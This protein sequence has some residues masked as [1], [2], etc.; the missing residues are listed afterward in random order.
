MRRLPI[1]LLALAATATVG[2][3]PKTAVNAK[4]DADAKSGLDGKRSGARAIQPNTPVTDEV[5]YLHQDQS[6]WY[7][8]QLPGH[9]GVLNTLVHWDNGASDIQIDV[10]DA[11]G[12][13][14][15]ASPVRNP[16][17]KEKAL[18][19]Q[20]DRPGT[21]YV[22]VTAPTA[23][24]GSV[25]TMEAKWD[26]PPPAPPPPPTPQ[27]MAMTEPAPPPVRRHRERVEREPREPRERPAGET[28]EGRIVSAY[29]EGGGLTLQLDKGAEAGLRPGMT[30][31]VLDGPSGQEPLSG[32]DFRVVSV[33]GASKSVAKSQLHSIGRNTRVLITLSR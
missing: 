25:Y 33:L 21:Y 1:L 7:V 20:I 14:I 11:F 27:P 30:G 29:R 2:C 22:R 28:V 5:N 15:S 9:A 23:N 32:G 26:V 17:A 31:T 10:F 19:T 18:L 13:Q 4:F 16:G 12:K 3:K 24:D 6:D 8:V